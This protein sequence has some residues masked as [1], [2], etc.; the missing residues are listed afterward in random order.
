MGAILSGL[1]LRRSETPEI[2]NGKLIRQEL[3]PSSKTWLIHSRQRS[4]SRGDTSAY[5]V[6][7]ASET[8]AQ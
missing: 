1:L 5:C 3:A 8:A 6:Y 4:P 7:P 2:V